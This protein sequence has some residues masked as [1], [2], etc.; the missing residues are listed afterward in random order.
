MNS[1][2][3]KPDNQS[4]Q[5]SA[6]HSTGSQDPSETRAIQAHCLFHGNQEILI[7]HNGEH[8]RL[9]ITR[10]NKLILTK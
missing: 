1:D 4:M 10:N 6:S 8:Y 2:Q 7:S 5:T 3:P 9:R